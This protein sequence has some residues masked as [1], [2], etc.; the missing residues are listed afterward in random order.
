MKKKVGSAVVTNRQARRDYAI[1]ESIEAGIELKGTEVK[2]L[3]GRLANLKESFARIEK[4]EVILYNFHISPYEFGNIHNVDPMRPRKLLLH[5]NQILRLYAKIHT[6]NLTLI[7][8]KVYFQKGFA[9]V[10]LAVAKGK[11][12]YDKR[13]AIKRREAKREIDRALR[14]KRRG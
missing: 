10:E 7:P 6:R 8:L 4:E 12:K 2:S 11:K 9:K 5:K 13:E 14:S 3:R 1:L